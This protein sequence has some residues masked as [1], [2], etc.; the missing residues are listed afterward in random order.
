MDDD[1]EASY[2]LIFRFQ[3]VEVPTHLFVV[4]AAV[5]VE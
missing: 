3:I 4:L 5:R 1:N 2:Y